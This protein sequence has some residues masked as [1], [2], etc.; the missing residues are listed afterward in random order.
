VPARSN[1]FQRIVKYIYEQ[2]SDVATVTESGLLRERD[3]TEREVDILIEWK[4]AGTS[5][6]MAV[7]CRDYTRQQ[8]IQWVDQLIGKYKDLKVNKIIAVSSSKFYLPAKRKAGEHGIEVITVNEALTKDWRAEI[9]RWKVMTHSFTLMRIATLKPN[10]ETFTYSEITADGKTATHRDQI[11]EYMYNLLWPFFMQ[12]L[13]QQV[14]TALEAKIAE[15]WQYF[16]GDN[17]PSWAEI[18]VKNPGLMKDGNPLDVEKIVFGVATFFHVGSP[19]SH[20]AMREHVLSDVVIKTMQR[21]SKLRFIFD[22]DAKPVSIDFGDGKI[23]RGPFQP[24][25]QPH[26]L[27]QAGAEPGDE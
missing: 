12:R 21:D 1:D 10:G 5:L 13:S 25:L 27:M 7:E 26:P 23:V 19:G 8:N 22:R 17:T 11:S 4:F 24:T 20:F 6:Q 15:R 3:G 9:E 18:W 14:G 2:I 16:V